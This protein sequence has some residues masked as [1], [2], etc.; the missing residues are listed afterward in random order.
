L[1]DVLV[2]V[3]HGGGGDHE[4]E[5]LGVEIVVRHFLLALVP[6]GEFIKYGVMSDVNVPSAW[7]IGS[8]SL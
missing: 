8:I 7:I 2:L 1:I 6:L 3:C 4:L 5:W